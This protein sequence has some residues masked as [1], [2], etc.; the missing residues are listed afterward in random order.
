M[1]ISVWT[2]LCLLAVLL[3]SGQARAQYTTHKVAHYGATVFSSGDEASID[4]FD[5]RGKQVGILIFMP[6][7]AAALPPAT[8]DSAGVIRLYYVRA[9]YLEAVDMLRNEAPVYLR[10]WHGA[11]NNS[12]LSTSPDEPVG[13]AE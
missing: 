2:V 13:E 10:N 4:L 12:H 6:V 8:Q 9:R 3:H 11:G 1:K 5:A 7:T